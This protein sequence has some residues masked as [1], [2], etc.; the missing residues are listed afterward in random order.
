ME[1]QMIVLQLAAMVEQQQCSETQRTSKVVL[2][3]VL[4]SEEEAGIEP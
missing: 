2:Q 3:Q 1:G 4:A